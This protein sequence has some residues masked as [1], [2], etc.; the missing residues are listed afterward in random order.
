MHAEGGW[1]SREKY[2]KSVFLAK[3]KLQIHERE[4]MSI[5][6]CP[7]IHLCVSLEMPSMVVV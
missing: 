4:L 6:T 5:I 7:K 1:V 2:A 3:V